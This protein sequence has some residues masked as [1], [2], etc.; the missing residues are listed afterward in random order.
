MG[1][2]TIYFPSKLYI[3]NN[4]VIVSIAENMIFKEEKRYTNLY[5]NE[6]SFIRKKPDLKYYKNSLL[7]CG[8]YEAI[9][10]FLPDAGSRQ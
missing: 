6:F 4:L 3:F 10:F 8:Q 5:L 1:A 9:H 2:D 7:L